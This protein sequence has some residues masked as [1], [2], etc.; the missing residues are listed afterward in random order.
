MDKTKKKKILIVAAAIIAIIVT[1]VLIRTYGRKSQH[2][3][4]ETVKVK[5]GSVSNTVTATGTIEAIKTVQVGTQVSG[6][7]SKIYVDYNSRVKAGQLLAELDRRP[8]TTALTISEAALDD[9]KSEMTYQTANY[10]RI[11]ALFDKKLVAESDYDLALYN[12]EKAKTSL[13][14]AQLNYDRAKINLAYAYICS[15]IDG[16]VLKRA[17]DE[18]QTVAASFSTPT[19]F[20]IANDLT[21]MQVEAS[22]DEADI[23]QVRDGQ[24]VDFTVDAYPDD[25]F[26]GTVTQIR[27]EPVVTSNVVT[28]TVIVNAPNPYKKLMP[29]MTA[30]IT[31]Y[32]EVA[33][34]VLTVSSKALRFKPNSLVMKAYY[35]SLP[36]DKR[37]DSLS[38]YGHK[39]VPGSM[40]EKS[41]RPSAG[42]TQR[43]GSM[44]QAG[45]RQALTGSPVP[46]S[47]ASPE[48]S[49]NQA[50]NEKET[51]VWVKTRDFIHPVKIETGIDNDIDV[52][53]I[54]GLKE[55]DE[56]VVS[57]S[58][59]TKVKAAK[60]E[61]DA[62]SPF[63]PRPPFRRTR[64]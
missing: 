45:R 18:G 37:L 50:V 49:S 51:E 56:V 41:N 20:T 29:G 27:L 61:E 14:T 6:E 15:P 11:K 59:D 38:E 62:S 24:S 16:V 5:I 44:A 60:S 33:N 34:N 48:D 57:M 8:L 3:S 30:N 2:V 26:T 9:A 31:I 10:N 47:F 1:F 4:V 54:S 32:V 36:A 64:R 39:R 19:L 13:K 22:I 46:G 40:A 28:Y 35:E 52:Q 42:K 63:M 12:Y 23:G 58:M 25:K 55:G 53:I 7:V 17:V 43:Y 21:R